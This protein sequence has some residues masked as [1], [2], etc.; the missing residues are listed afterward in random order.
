MGAERTAVKKK[1]R[2]NQTA[3]CCIEKIAEQKRACRRLF[4]TD[5]CL[6]E[7]DNNER[8]ER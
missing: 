1:D 5:G 2:R 4:G 6:K 7:R 3:V 8:N